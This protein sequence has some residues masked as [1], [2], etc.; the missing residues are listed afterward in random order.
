MQWS[1][2]CEGTKKCVKTL[3]AE[4][5]ISI[6]SN[7]AC[8]GVL[9]YLVKFEASVWILLAL[10]S[11]A[12]TRDFPWSWQE[13]LRLITE[14]VVFV[15]PFLSLNPMQLHNE[16]QTTLCQVRLSFWDWGRICYCL[17]RLLVPVSVMETP[18]DFY[19]SIFQIQTRMISGN[20]PHHSTK[21]SSLPFPQLRSTRLTWDWVRDSTTPRAM[22]RT[23]TQ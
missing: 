22:T 21:L 6:W 4:E 23:W 12:K 13:I 15:F 1:K 17:I 9:A 5:M 2:S 14:S 10:L 20:F 3:V 8:A 7:Y 19:I 16:I 18:C 11:L